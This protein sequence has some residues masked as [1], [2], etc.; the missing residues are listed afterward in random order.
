[1]KHHLLLDVLDPENCLFDIVN[2]FM[3]FCG[4]YNRSSSLFT[5]PSDNCSEVQEKYEDGDALLA[6]C[7]TDGEHTLGYHYHSL[8]GLWRS[9]HAVNSQLHFI[10]KRAGYWLH[11][12]I[13]EK[14]AEALE[15]R[16]SPSFYKSLPKTLS[17]ELFDS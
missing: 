13:N 17:E 1:L 5:R 7:K 2:R 8:W 9:H 11:P 10:R 12:Y 6:V 16:A 14:Y 4:Y 15:D 3:V